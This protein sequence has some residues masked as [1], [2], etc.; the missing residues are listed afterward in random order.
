MK[1]TVYPRLAAQV[2]GR[3]SIIPDIHKVNDQG[4]NHCTEQRSNYLFSGTE[5]RS[6]DPKELRDDNRP[7]LMKRWV[8]TDIFRISQDKQEEN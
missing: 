1:L 6:R 5:E 2:I 8:S 4:R 7:K 3:I